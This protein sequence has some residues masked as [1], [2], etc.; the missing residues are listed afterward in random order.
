MGLF[1]VGSRSVAG[2]TAELIIGDHKVVATKEDWGRYWV[3]T[4]P[5]GEVY[6]SASIV[7]L[8]R[9][10]KDDL[11]RSRRRW[12]ERWSGKS[13]SPPPARRGMTGR[14]KGETSVAPEVS[15]RFG[16]TGRSK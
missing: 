8:E 13:N 4:G 14:G 1:T 10:L 11:L 16:M 6:R 7:D 5:N 3:T 2:H 9:Q 12:R 15:A